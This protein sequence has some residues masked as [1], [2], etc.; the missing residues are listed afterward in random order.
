MAAA[1]HPVNTRTVGALA[2]TV[3]ATVPLAPIHILA[4]HATQDIN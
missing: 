2:A 4:P 3:V 1:A